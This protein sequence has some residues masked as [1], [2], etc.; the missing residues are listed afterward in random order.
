MC[1]LKVA[2]SLSKKPFVCKGMREA[3]ERSHLSQTPPLMSYHIDGM[4]LCVLYSGRCIAQP[5]CYHPPVAS[6]VMRLP[7]ADMIVLVGMLS[8]CSIGY[9]TIDGASSIDSNRSI[10]N[11]SLAS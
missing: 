6:L 8:N 5:S 9:Y 7:G 1:N 3:L 2:H 4:I 11:C 10:N